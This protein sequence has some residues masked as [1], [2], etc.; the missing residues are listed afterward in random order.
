MTFEELYMQYADCVYSFLRFKIRDVH[1]MEDMFQET[2]LA[3]YR[4]LQAGRKPERPKPWLLTIAHRR[5][6]DRLRRLPDRETA[7]RESIPAG[8]SGGM[9]WTEAIHFSDL[10]N[11]LDESARTILYAQYVE[12]LSVGEIAAMLDIPEGT[13]KSRAYH[14]KC[15]LSEWLKE[16]GPNGA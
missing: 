12:G 9:D 10:M 13:V 11:R 15:K 7:L 8:G 5:M 4:E 14:A 3:A 6:V 16:G 2:F 1:L